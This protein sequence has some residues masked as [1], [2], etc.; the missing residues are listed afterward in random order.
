MNYKRKRDAK[1]RNKKVE[2][3]IQEQPVQEEPKDSNA[4][5]EAREFI[6][7]KKKK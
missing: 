2:E 7:D 3:V 4:M 1:A 6:K 5:H